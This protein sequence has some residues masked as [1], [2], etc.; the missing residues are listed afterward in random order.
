MLKV[1]IMRCTL[2]ITKRLSNAI[3]TN[4][5]LSF[6]STPSYKIRNPHAQE[7]TLEA[8]KSLDEIFLAVT[9]FLDPK[10]QER[11][12]QDFLFILLRN[13]TKAIFSY[14]CVL[15]LSPLCFPPFFFRQPSTKI[16]LEVQTALPLLPSHLAKAGPDTKS[17]IVRPDTHVVLNLSLHLDQVNKQKRTKDLKAIIITI[18]GYDANGMEVTLNPLVT[19]IKCKVCLVILF[20]YLNGRDINENSLRPCYGLTSLPLHNICSTINDKYKDNNCNTNSSKPKCNSDNNTSR[21]YY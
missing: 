2:E 14:I 19:K 20:R 11:L 1:N 4:A 6:A 9:Y 10:R 13:A 8:I 18:R 3:T 21:C 12:P 17:Y 16:R 15:R 5:T 7:A